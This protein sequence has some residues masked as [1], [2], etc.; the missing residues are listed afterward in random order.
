MAEEAGQEVTEAGPT[1]EEAIAAYDRL[2]EKVS[3]NW[4]RHG[5]TFERFRR[6]H[7]A[8]LP[9]PGAEILD[10]GAGD[11]LNAA[12]LAG[13]G[14]RV[15]AVEPSAGM[16]A[17]AKERP[18]S[19]EILWLDDRLPD[20]DAVRALGRRFPFVLMNAV[21]MHV[22]PNLRERAMA[23]LADLVAP[24]GYFSV[25]LRHG[26]APEGRPMHDADSAPFLALATANDFNILRNETKPDPENRPGVSFTRIILKKRP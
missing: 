11:G 19:G 21:W 7:E 12:G 14:Y 26:P 15:V 9:Q 10:V 24:D 23:A 20:L 13:M 4:D 2:A 22:P 5:R 8:Y 16:R 1:V 25:L 6:Y 18:D 3:A 17:V